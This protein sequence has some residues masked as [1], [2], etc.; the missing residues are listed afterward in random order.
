MAHH[1]YS[2]LPTGEQAAFEQACA[3]YG[4]APTQFE[5]TDFIDDTDAAHNRVVTVRRCGGCAQLYRA[6]SAEWV[7]EFEA[8]LTYRFFK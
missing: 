4:F 1:D 8:D 2:D 6:G 3:R 5:I 7:R